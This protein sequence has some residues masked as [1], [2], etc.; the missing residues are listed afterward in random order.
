M[1]RSIRTGAETSRSGAGICKRH[2]DLLG[3]AIVKGLVEAHGGKIGVESEPGTG[4]RF[5]FE[6]PSEAAEGEMKGDLPNAVASRSQ[7]G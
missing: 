6:L 7:A 3:L 4:A 1:V 5:H 2:S